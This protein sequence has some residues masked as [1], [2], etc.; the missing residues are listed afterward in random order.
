MW[1]IRSLLAL[2]LMVCVVGFAYF[3]VS[4]YQ[5]VNVNLVF[6][7]YINVPLL[8]V[9]FWSFAAGALLSLILFIAVYI[10]L[11]I[12]LRHN[13]RR[14]QALEHEVAVLRNRPIE[15]SADLLRGSDQKA[16]GSASVL[17]EID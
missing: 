6:A 7:K 11:S 13:H 15:E 12:E 5:T 3:N 10:K 4:T 1:A 9:V 16:V 2:A 14:I 8:T 17:G